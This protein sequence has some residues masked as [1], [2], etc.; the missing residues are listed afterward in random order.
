MVGKRVR[1]RQLSPGEWAVLEQLRLAG[2]PV[3]E[4][5]D[6]AGLSESW[7]YRKLGQMAKDTPAVRLARQR[8]A[9]EAD[10]ARIQAAFRDEAPADVARRARAF[11]AVLKASKDLEGWMTP[12][13][14]KAEPT[15]DDMPS[16]EDL[17]AELERRFAALDAGRAAACG[18]GENGPA[19]ADGDAGGLDVLGPDRTAPAGD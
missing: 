12:K 11:S 19:R 15:D 2:V 10:L 7:T 14:T 6:R 18:H 5:A 17:C 13:D 9:M 8:A 3:G 1:K 4:I 16:V